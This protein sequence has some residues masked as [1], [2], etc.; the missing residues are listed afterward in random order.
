VTERVFFFFI[1]A[2]TSL[3]VHFVFSFQGL[4]NSSNLGN[5]TTSQYNSYSSA[6]NHK[7]G[8]DSGYDNTSNTVSNTQTTTSS[9]VTSTTALSLSQSTVSVTKSTTTL[10]TLVVEFFRW[11]FFDGRVLTFSCQEFQ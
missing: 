4:N 10:G 2:A 3:I 11:G 1:S 6:S 5:T 8:K 7:L 9:N